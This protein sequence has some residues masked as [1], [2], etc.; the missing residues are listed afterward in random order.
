MSRPL[1]IVCTT[2]RQVGQPTAKML[3]RRAKTFEVAQHAI[4]GIM[5]VGVG[6]AVNTSMKFCA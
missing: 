1:C 5:Y 2:V 6:R 4:A 3:I